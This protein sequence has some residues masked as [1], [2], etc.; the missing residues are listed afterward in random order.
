MS[1]KIDN[2]ILFWMRHLTKEGM[3]NWEARNKEIDRNGFRPVGMASEIEFTL[4]KFYIQD[5]KVMVSLEF[6]EEKLGEAMMKCS[7]MHN[8]YSKIL[9][10]AMNQRML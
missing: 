8:V 10:S 2:V 3:R 5:G 9:A 6:V 7:K 4:E 1:S